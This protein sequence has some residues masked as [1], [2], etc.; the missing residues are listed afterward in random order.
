MSFNKKNTEFNYLPNKRVISDFKKKI[1]EFDNSFINYDTLNIIT[2]SKIL[3]SE[4]SLLT[5]SKS[6]SG[7]SIL[8]IAIINGTSAAFAWLMASMV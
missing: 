2:S 5:F 7:K 3:F 1:W 6:M 8:L 4:S